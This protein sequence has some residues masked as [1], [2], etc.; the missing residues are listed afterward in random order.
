M[1]LIF[2]VFLQGQ[3]F[4]RRILLFCLLTIGATV[5]RRL[6]FCV[7][8]RF[9]FLALFW[10]KLLPNGLGGMKTFHHFLKPC[11]LCAGKKSIRPEAL[12]NDK[13]CLL[14]LLNVLQC[15]HILK[16]AR[17]QTLRQRSLGDLNTALPTFAHVIES[18]PGNISCPL[19]PFVRRPE[20][21]QTKSTHCSSAST[22]IR[23]QSPNWV[24]V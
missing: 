12:D 20:P 11:L 8:K 7:D 22:I 9:E 19:Q 6:L 21:W 3:N 10:S 24:G 23:S 14:F 1:K 15:F 16:A 17:L 18:V 13:K 5:N 4:G 2:I